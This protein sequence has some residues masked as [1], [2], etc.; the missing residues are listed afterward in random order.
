MDWTALGLVGVIIAFIC[1][2]FVPL[3]AVIIL[4][5]YFATYFGLSGVV[6]WSFVIVCVLIVMGLIG[7]LSRGER[8]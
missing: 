2:C 8:L 7:T 6:W 3:A 1:I 5:T 4:S